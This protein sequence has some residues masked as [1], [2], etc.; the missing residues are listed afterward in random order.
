MLHW[1][2]VLFFV[3]ITEKASKSNPLLCG[4]KA[5]STEPGWTLAHM[6]F[7]RRLTGPNWTHTHM[8][9]TG[10]S[11]LG[12]YAPSLANADGTVHLLAITSRPSFFSLSLAVAPVHGCLHWQLILKVGFVCVFRSFWKAVGRFGRMKNPCSIASSFSLPSL[13]TASAAAS[14]ALFL[15]IFTKFHLA[16]SPDSG[17][18][19]RFYCSFFTLTILKAAQMPRRD[20]AGEHLHSRPGGLLSPCCGPHGLHRLCWNLPNASHGPPFSLCIN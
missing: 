19:L 4:A 13:L 6:C 9:F 12:V 18:F 10:P 7:W 16:F 11:I 20:L 3:Y 5:Y 14:A 2:G 8:W 15:V 1:K 17:G